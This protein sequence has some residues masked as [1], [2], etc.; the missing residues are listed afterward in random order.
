MA[1]DDDRP[2]AATGVRGITPP[3]RRLSKDEK[4]PLRWSA[5]GVRGVTPPGKLEPG[6]GPATDWTMK[7]AG[8]APTRPKPGAKAGGP[9]PGE[10]VNAGFVPDVLAGGD[11]PK[12]FK[13]FLD[14][15][16]AFFRDHKPDEAAMVHLAELIGQSHAPYEIIVGFTVLSALVGADKQL[17]SRY[18]WALE[19]GAKAFYNLAMRLDPRVKPPRG[20]S[21]QRLD[22]IFY[23]LP[24][25][26]YQIPYAFATDAFVRILDLVRG[27]IA[28]DRKLVA[29][30]RD[31]HARF[32]G[33]RSFGDKPL[34]DLFPFDE[35]P[36]A[37][38]D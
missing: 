16:A 3:G 13:V 6:K 14:E 18:S 29:F 38:G 34:A 35:P 2:W 31:L 12:S 11:D 37:P 21:P 22:P 36:W 30:A 8:A 33:R 1:G 4:R 9:Q 20:L 5:S 26:A 32:V 19:R 7:R 24:A 23:D 25:T 27:D 10:R 17:R 15:L 28:H